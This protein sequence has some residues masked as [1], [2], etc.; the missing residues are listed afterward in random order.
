MVFEIT[1]FYCKPDMTS[2]WYLRQGAARTF[3]RW[4]ILCTS[5][6]DFLKRFLSKFFLGFIVSEITWFYCKPDM[7]SS[8]VLRHAL[9]PDWFWKSDPSFIIMVNRHIS[10]VSHRFEVKRHFMLAGN[11]PFRPIVLVFKVKSPQILQLHISYCKKSLLYTR[12]RFL[13]YR[14]RKSVYWYVL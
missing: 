1:R 10:R 4:L 9:F 13:S 6:Q 8:S 11:C 3:S 14:A 7:T 2:S 5:D 12:P